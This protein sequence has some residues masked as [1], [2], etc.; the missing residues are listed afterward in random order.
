M[1]N[2]VASTASLHDLEPVQPVRSVPAAAPA[3]PE[4]RQDMADLR[5]VIEEN[6][7]TGTFVYKTIDRRTGEVVSQIP[8]EDMLK[9]RE[10]AGYEAGAVIKTQV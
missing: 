4:P 10:D 6:A 9:L 1:E 7:N 5:L 8:R 2:K 3:A